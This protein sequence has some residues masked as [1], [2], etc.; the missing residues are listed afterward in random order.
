MSP[1]KK[2]VL[3]AD[4]NKSFQVFLN[5]LLGRLGFHVVTA[6]D[7][8]E[9]VDLARLVSPD[10]VTLDMEMPRMTGLEALASLK[11]DEML[12]DIPVVMISASIKG[13]VIERCKEL[14][15]YRYMDKPVDIPELNRTIQECLFSS[16]GGGRRYLRVNA[17][18]EVSLSHHGS[19]SRHTTDTLSERGV[20]IMMDRPLPVGSD[21][22]VTLSLGRKPMEIRGTVIYAKVPQEDAPGAAT[23]VAVEFSDVGFRE[24]SALRDYIVG[25]LTEGI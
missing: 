23:G 8:Q 24:S 16:T 21:V 14:G 18:I 22:T 10:L 5:I 9:A 3:V 17:S 13:D 15:V 1:Q 25:I 11:Q 7:G 2:T 4:D 20:Y 19:V 12:R 6:D